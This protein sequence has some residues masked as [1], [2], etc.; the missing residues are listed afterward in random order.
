MDDVL[1]IYAMKSHPF[2][3][4]M[5][6]AWGSILATGSPAVDG[7]FDGML[8]SL[9]RLAQMNNDLND[10]CGSRGKEKRF[11]DLMG[12]SN[13]LLTYSLFRSMGSAEKVRDAIRRGAAEA[14]SSIDAA[15]LRRDA[16][17]AALALRKG[18]KEALDGLSGK[19]E[20]ADACAS[21]KNYADRLTNDIVSKLR[22]M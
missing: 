3:T 22:K 11:E 2:T 13:T 14:L 20:R 17:S 8:L 16:L 9:T 12:F 4:R 1:E 10:L 19:G 15:G 7:G 18:C 6:S 5:L 21:Y